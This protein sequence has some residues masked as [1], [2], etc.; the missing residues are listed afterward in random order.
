MLGCVKIGD[1]PLKSGWWTDAPLGLGVPHVQSVTQPL[2]VSWSNLEYQEWLGY[3]G[4]EID[5]NL[6][7]LDHLAMESA[8]LGWLKEK[9]AGYLWFNPQSSGHAAE[10]VWRGRL[11]YPYLKMTN[12]IDRIRIVQFWYETIQFGEYLIFS[13]LISM[14]MWQIQQKKHRNRLAIMDMVGSPKGLILKIWITKPDE[15]RRMMYTCLE[16]VT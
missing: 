6:A 16:T 7:G 10:A 1:T 2:L 9:S 8:W 11:L 4:H 3:L 12:Y 14:S 5:C 13:L 15:D